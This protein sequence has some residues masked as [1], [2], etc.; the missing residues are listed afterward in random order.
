MRNLIIAF[1]LLFSLQSAGQSIS[2]STF[3]TQNIK[4]VAVT[5][6]G[7]I[8]NVGGYDPGDNYVTRQVALG[9]TEVLAVSKASWRPYLSLVT[10]PFK[11]RP[12]ID[13]FSQNV[14]TGLAN[15]GIATNIFNY[16]LTRYFNSGKQSTHQF[17]VGILIAPTAEELSPENTNR[18]VNKKSK[19]LFISAGLSLTYTYNDITFVILPVAYDFATTTDGKNYVYNKKNWWGFG[20]GITT[21]LFGLF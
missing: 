20:V 18:F 2:L 5:S 12:A 7:G 1:C 15:A 9:P 19:Q 17:G 4:V 6:T 11:V 14:Q 13:T 3:L 8:L 21:K 16:K 10:I